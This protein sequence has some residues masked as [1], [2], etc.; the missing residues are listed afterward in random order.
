MQGLVLGFEFRLNGLVLTFT[1]IDGMSNVFAAVTSGIMSF[2]KRA[3]ERPMQQW[4][5]SDFMTNISHRRIDVSDITRHSSQ[6]GERPHNDDSLRRGGSLRRDDSSKECPDD[7]Q[8]KGKAPGGTSSHSLFKGSC[9]VSL[10]SVES[11][12]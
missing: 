2:R 5:K 10:N 7:S 9:F 11:V 12:I 1:M 4:T 6:E 3:G 8:R